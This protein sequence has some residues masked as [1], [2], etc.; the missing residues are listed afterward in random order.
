MEIEEPPAPPVVL[1]IAGSDNS[2]GAGAQ[3]DLKTFT[4]AGVYGLTAITCVVAE[5]PGRVTCIQPVDP[6]VVRQQIELSFAHFPV[7]AVKTGMLH[8]RVIIELVAELIAAQDPRPKLVV[9]PVMVA[10]SGDAL[11]EPDA[12][13]SYVEKLF[14]LASL[15]T[16]NLDEAGALLGRTINNL[17][18]MRMAGRELADRFAVPVLL[19]GGHLGGE[20]AT[21]LLIFPGGRTV[22]FSAPF[23][24]GV[25]THGTGCTF[26]AAITACLA[27]GVELEEAVQ[28]AKEFVTT[29]V[30]QHFRWESP[31]GRV[32]ALNHFLLPP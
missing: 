1:T 19:K 26:A 22:E 32:D 6:I 31:A 4:A 17:I 23:T 10:T 18:G 29:A 24:R 7:A 8:S 12:L 27:M 20:I 25:S 28:Q 2:S 16:P 15:L 11:L 13:A 5:V 21:D 3:A 14:P 9:D 30:R